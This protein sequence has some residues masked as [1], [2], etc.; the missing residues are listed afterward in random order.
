[1]HSGGDI[2]GTEEEAG[3]KTGSLPNLGCRGRS[4]DF[5]VLSAKDRFVAPGSRGAGIQCVNND[6]GVYARHNVSLPQLSDYTRGLG[7][8]REKNFF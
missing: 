8:Q 5:P 3:Q 2:G 4:M 1:M 6:D 7:R